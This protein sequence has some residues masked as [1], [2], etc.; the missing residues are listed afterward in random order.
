MLAADVADLV[1]EG[2]ALAMLKL[3]Y[4]GGFDDVAEEVPVGEGGGLSG[5]LGPGGEE[6]VVEEDDLS[7]D[8]YDDDGLLSLS[9]LL[10]SL[11]LLLL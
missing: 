10:L 9:L 8:V 11:L 7:D 1:G 6:E 4:S 3:L 5:L 2:D